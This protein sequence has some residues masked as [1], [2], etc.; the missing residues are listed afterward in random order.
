MDV[1]EAACKV[2]TTQL[3][4]A[5]PGRR[6]GRGGCR[7]LGH[8]AGGHAELGRAALMPEPQLQDLEAE[9]HLHSVPVAII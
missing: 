9:C 6:R 4:R 3:D 7:S 1:L 2:C 5:E 8:R